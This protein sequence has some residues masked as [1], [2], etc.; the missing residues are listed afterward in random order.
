M[1]FANDQVSDQVIFRGTRTRTKFS[2]SLKMYAEEVKKW[3]TEADNEEQ[4]QREMLLNQLQQEQ[5][6]Q[7]NMSNEDLHDRTFTV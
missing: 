7:S 1:A 2:F 5:L 6:I 3:L 4:R